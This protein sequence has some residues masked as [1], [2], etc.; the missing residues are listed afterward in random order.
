MDF[1]RANPFVSREEYIWGWTVPQIKL[2][3]MDF[4]HMEYLPESAGKF[5][6]VDAITLDS[7]GSSFALAQIPGFK[8]QK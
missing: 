1:L 8:K 6:N 2:A 3:G 5:G 4:S 7:P